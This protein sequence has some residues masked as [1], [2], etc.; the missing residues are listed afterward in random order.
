MSNLKELKKE[1]RRLMSAW[2]L[3]MFALNEINQQ[4]FEIREEKRKIK[5]QQAEIE[6]ENKICQ[7]IEKQLE[8]TLERN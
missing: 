7:K 3:D 2:N 6:L 8:R 5:E 4:I 1:Q